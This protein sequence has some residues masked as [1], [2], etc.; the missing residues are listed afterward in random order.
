MV[1]K[2]VC[3]SLLIASLYSAR[4]LVKC[5]EVRRD[6]IRVLNSVHPFNDEQLPS[7]TRP[8]KGARTGNG[9]TYVRSNYLIGANRRMGDKNETLDPSNVTLV[10]EKE[11]E[12]NKKDD[13]SAIAYLDEYRVLPIQTKEVK[14]ITCRG[15]HCENVEFKKPEKG[16]FAY[17]FGLVKPLPDTL[18]ATYNLVCR[19]IEDNDKRKCNIELE[20]H[21]KAKKEEKGERENKNKHLPFIFGF[22]GA[23]L[24]VVLI[25]LVVFGLNGRGP[26]KKFLKPDRS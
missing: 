18:I 2:L 4:S 25:L 13:G 6:S 26:L 14:N 24:L 10:K 12:G 23:E 11:G 15:D 19:N 8:D 16:N 9:W 21:E 17:T 1:P 7:L 20:L 22:L 3:L 5:E